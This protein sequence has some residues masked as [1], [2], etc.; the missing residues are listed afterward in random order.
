[1]S[2]RHRYSNRHSTEIC[3]HGAGFSEWNHVFHQISKGKF[4]GTAAELWLG[5][6]QL[7]HDVSNQAIGHSGTSWR[8]SQVFISYLPG[9]AT[10][11]IEGNRYQPDTIVTNFWDA[12]ERSSASAGFESVGVVVDRQCLVAYARD[13]LGIHAPLGLLDMGMLG[14]PLAKVRQFQQQI[15]SALAIP[16][17]THGEVDL[18][19]GHAIRANILNLILDC[20]VEDALLWSDLPASSTRDYIVNRA[21]SIIEADLSASLS[22]V[23]ICR[24]LKISQRTLEYSFQEVIGTSPHAYIAMR[25]LCEVRR[26]IISRPELPVKTPALRYGFDHLGRFSK[27]YQSAFDEKPSDTRARSRYNAAVTMISTL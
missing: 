14:A 7:F 9:P 13:Y 1:M 15:L 12:V 8:N 6:V 2:G 22:V 16:Q 21:Q 18:A 4:I 24:K 5:D 3:S 19:I 25:R 11:K 23:D 20:V 10:I 26:A 17:A 27:I